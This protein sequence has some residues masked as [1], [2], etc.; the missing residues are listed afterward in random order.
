MSFL[1]TDLP[2]CYVNLQDTSVDDAGLMD[3]LNRAPR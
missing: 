3:L 2:V 1:V